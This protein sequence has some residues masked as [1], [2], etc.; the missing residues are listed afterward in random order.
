[1]GLHLSVPKFQTVGK[2]LCV[3]V[4]RAALALVEVEV[5]TADEEEG[6]ETPS[7]LE[8][9]KSPTSG[10]SNDPGGLSCRRVRFSDS[11]LP[12]HS[13]WGKSSS[14]LLQIQR[15]VDG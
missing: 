12:K 7:P 3:F 5:V 1:M 4:R 13:Y 2:F 11:R 14:P 6:D 15:E 8:I 9:A 10:T